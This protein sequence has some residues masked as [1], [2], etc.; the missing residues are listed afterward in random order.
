MDSQF[1]YAM[2][3]PYIYEGNDKETI[4]L[5]YPHACGKCS[6]P[7]SPAWCS[8]FNTRY[9]DKVK[10]KDNPRSRFITV[11]FRETPA[12]EKH[13][14]QRTRTEHIFGS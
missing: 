5:L 6:C 10:I 7:I 4:R 3:Y 12:F 2:N 13:Y 9:V 8:S 14:N 11:P 1:V